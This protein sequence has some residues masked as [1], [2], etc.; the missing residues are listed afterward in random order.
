MFHLPQHATCPSLYAFLNLILY[1]HIIKPLTAL[2]SFLQPPGT[3]SLT[4][5]YTCPHCSWTS[6]NSTSP[7]GKSPKLFNFKERYT[8]IFWNTKFK[9][10]T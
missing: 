9:N 4:S 8:G 6:S 2:H 5:K 7:Q 10:N 1:V 3:I